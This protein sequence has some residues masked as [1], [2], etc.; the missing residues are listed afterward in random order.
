MMEKK[1]FGQAGIA[2]ALIFLGISTTML[3]IG[4]P[5]GIAE[6]LEGRISS[7][8]YCKGASYD[9]L[10]IWEVLFTSKIGECSLGN[11]S[12]HNAWILRNQV[13]T[14]MVILLI[15][16]SIF[17]Y[18]LAK[19]GPIGASDVKTAIG[20]GFIGF[21]LVAVATFVLFVY[22]IFVA[23][24]FFLLLMTGILVTSRK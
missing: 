15:V 9:I 16:V 12:F 20:I 5:K 1:Q 17:T 6:I 3:L 19:D 4:L 21:G 2:Q 14:L 13:L 7:E 22:A 24:G 10:S 8:G 11:H 23:V 18:K